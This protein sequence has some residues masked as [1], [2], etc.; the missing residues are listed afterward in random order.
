MIVLSEP[1]ARPSVAM[2]TMS[3]VFAQDK[4]ALWLTVDTP[5]SEN[6]MVGPALSVNGYVLVK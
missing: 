4:P 5:L 2:S 3:L 1:E 6:M